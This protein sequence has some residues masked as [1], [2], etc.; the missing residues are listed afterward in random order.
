MSTKQQ[1]LHI[2]G[3][4]PYTT[5]KNYID[6]LTNGR[7]ELTLEDPKKWNKNHRSFLD[8]EL[9]EVITPTMPCGWRARYGD[10]KIWFERHV[11]FLRDGVVLVGHSLG[12]NFLVKWLSENILPV[13]ISQLHLVAASYSEF[14][15]DFKITEFPKNIF[16]NK[17][18]EIH[19]YH[20]ADDTIV[21]IAESHKYFEALP[22]SHLHIFEDRFHFLDETFPEL[23]EN[24]QSIQNKKTC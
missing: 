22:G 19:I 2:H 10:W 17:I 9:Y 6:R 5:E 13:Q 23:F 24:I 21:P 18:H 1:I 15:D 4:E 12:G 14:D 7:F 11:E 16:E 8:S 3:G 20:S